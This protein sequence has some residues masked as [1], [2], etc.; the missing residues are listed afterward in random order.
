MNLSTENNEILETVVLNVP[1]T[2]VFEYQPTDEEGRPIGGKQVLKYTDPA[3]L[4]YLLAEQNTLLVRKLREQTKKNR[5]GIVDKDTI[6]E[7]A[8]KFPKPFGFTPKPLTKEERA[9]LSRDILDEDTFDSAIAKIVES[10][11]GITEVRDELTDLTQQVNTLNA[12]QQV[13]IF[14]SN[15]PEYIICDENAQTLVGWLLRYDLA[16]TAQN[17]QTAYNKLKDAGVLVTSLERVTNPVYTPPA[18]PA[19][20]EDLTTLVDELPPDGVREE[21]PPVEEHPALAEPRSRVPLSLNRNSSSGDIANIPTPVGDQLVYE[22][23][24]PVTQKVLRTLTG[25]KALDALPS[26]EYK[27]RMR[28]PGFIALVNKIEAETA[29]RKSGGR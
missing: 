22:I 6:D 29:K 2:K 12:L 24:D 14:Q 1:E 28:Q 10:T 27:R 16:P 4:P 26:D 23:K 7:G 8:Q 13:A 25:Q 18:P 19:Q 21:I 9:Q 5:L 15:N 20:V 3:E 11:S 17:F